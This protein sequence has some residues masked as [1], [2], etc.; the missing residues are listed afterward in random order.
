MRR[1]A[2][3]LGWY[4]RGAVWQQFLGAQLT[5]CAIAACVFT[6]LAPTVAAQ[7]T[8]AVERAAARAAA[9]SAE[10]QAAERAAA[11]A[12]RGA[13]R[14]A[15]D[16]LVRRWSSALC[17]PSAP[18]PLPESV[19]NTFKG[20][21]YGEVVLGQETTVYRVYADPAHR[22]GRPGER[23]SYWSRSDARGTQAV[24]D[25]AIDVSRFGNTAQHQVAVRVPRGTRVYEGQ[26]QSI[27]RGP[28]GGGSQVVVEGVRPEWV[29]AR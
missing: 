20:G 15:T 8:S 7:V 29:L 17:K 27:E 10:R 28:V 3:Q 5:R 1:A 16:R 14:Q 13:G 23:Y 22:L 18:C 21:S 12:A 25:G 9:R 6:L 4:R 24:V 11:A 26:S 19:A 2:R